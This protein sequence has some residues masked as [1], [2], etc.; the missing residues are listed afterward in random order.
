MISHYRY[1]YLNGGLP[2]WIV[3]AQ[4]LDREAPALVGGPLPLTLHDEPN[5]TRGY[6]QSRLGAAD[7]AVR[8]ARNPSRYAGTKM[9]TAKAEYVPGVVNLE[10]TTG[11]NLACAL[12]ICA[13]IA[14]VLEDP[15]IAPN[16][17]VITHRQTHHRFGFTYLVAKTLGYPRVRGYAGSWSEWGN[18]PDAPVEV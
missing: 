2:A 12:Y 9:L 7:L 6:L 17:G 15:D 1:H 14:E 3:D 8:D 11:M 10:W 18:Y 16:K 4:V 5:A 13:D